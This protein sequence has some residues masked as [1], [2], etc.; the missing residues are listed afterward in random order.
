M[1]MT[2]G[3]LIAL[4][5]SLANPTR[6]EE[7]TMFLLEEVLANALRSEYEKSGCTV[8]IEKKGGG[9]YVVPRLTGVDDMMGEIEDRP[10]HGDTILG[11]AIKEG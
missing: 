1:K 8:L 2:I 3:D 9:R 5:R 10:K 7:R 6:S 11:Y 4:A